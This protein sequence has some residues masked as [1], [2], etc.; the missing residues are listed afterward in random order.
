[1]ITRP[2]N[3][4]SQIRLLGL[5]WGVVISAFGAYNLFSVLAT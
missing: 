4:N 3:A 2:A 1:M 5:I